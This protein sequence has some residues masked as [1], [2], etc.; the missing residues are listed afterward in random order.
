MLQLQYMV[1]HPL[2]HLLPLLVKHIEDTHNRIHAGH[3]GVA[4]KDI[5]QYLKDLEP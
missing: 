3:T 2:I 1:L 4:F 5:H